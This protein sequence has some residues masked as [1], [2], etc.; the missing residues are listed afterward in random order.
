E[1]ALRFRADTRI[2]QIIRDCCSGGAAERIGLVDL[3]KAQERPIVGNE[4]F[5]D[6][7]HFNFDGNYRVALAFAEAAERL[8]PA[9]QPR[10]RQAL[11]EWP[12]QTE[13]ARR[14]GWTDWN[15]YEAE[16]GM[17]SRMTDPPFTSQANHRQQYEQALARL[18]RL[19]PA[20][21]PAG[22]RLAEQFYQAA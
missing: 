1:D 16:S 19:Q 18:Q 4:L 22:L 3:E 15:R 6:H 2:N 17:L 13:C 20:R 11:R 7:V 10:G 21:E 9:L 14:L 8:V 5:Y 12:S